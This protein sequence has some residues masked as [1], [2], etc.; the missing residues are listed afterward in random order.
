MPEHA[1]QENGTAS[2]P[3][4]L[5]PSRQAVD[6]MLTLVA[7]LARRAIP[8]VHEVGVSLVRDGRLVTAACSDEVVRELDSAQYDTGEGP[9]VDALRDGRRTRFESASP[10]TRW[11]VFELAFS[12]TG[13]AS[14]LSLPLLAAGLPIGVLNLYSRAPEAPPAG[15]EHLAWAF[16]REAATI[17][18]SSRPHAGVE[19]LP[20]QFQDAARSREL[21]AQAQGILMER[22]G[23]PA[24]EAFDWLRRRSQQRG[25]KLR[26]VA[27]EVVDS[28][29]YPTELAEA[30]SA[31]A[32]RLLD[33]DTVVGTLGQIVNLA[34]ETID[35]CDY[36]GVS[37]VKGVSIGTPV[38][39]DEIVAAADAVQYETAEG[40]CLDAIRLQETFESRDLAHD[41][42]WPRFGPRVAGLGVSSLLSYHLFAH[43]STLGALNL[44]SR[45]V[46]AFDDTS[47][48]TAAIFAA[49]AAIALSVAQ[50]HEGTLEESAGMRAAL[51]SRDMIGQAKGILM[52]RENVTADQAFDVLRRASQHLNVKLREVAQ[53][54]TETGESP[55]PRAAA[56]DQ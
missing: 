43:E 44:Y 3:S 24:D 49:H 51:E 13:F 20:D 15:T 28:A 42:R 47:H 18:G 31:I 12:Q 37:L 46:A 36:A 19:E 29:S 7:S 5:A 10:N 11:P 40:P 14:V 16:A 25:T 55:D 1:G 4:R 26:V 8:G 6:A 45:T 2:D 56:T 21:I 53:R 54:V 50:S 39:S 34:V 35:G 33:A 22:E 30:F 41:A 17:L 23:F 9:C 32:R 52:E 48:R 38:F 27:Q